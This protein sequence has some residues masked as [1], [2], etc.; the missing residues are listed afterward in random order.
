MTGEPMAD[1]HWV[2][3][4]VG[5]GAILGGMPRGSGPDTAPDLLT[6]RKAPAPVQALI[7]SGATVRWPGVSSR[8]ARR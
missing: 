2:G 3:C 5:A 1:L 8:T 6:F 7:G 4:L